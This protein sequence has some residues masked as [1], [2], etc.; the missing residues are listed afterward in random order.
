MR[1]VFD[2]ILYEVLA[3]RHRQVNQHMVNRRKQTYDSQRSY[4]S[5]GG[6]KLFDG[7]MANLNLPVSVVGLQVISSFLKLIHQNHLKTHG[8]LLKLRSSLAG[9]TIA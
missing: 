3:S 8:N 2:L 6:R 5:E 4:L 9:T 1:Q 7:N